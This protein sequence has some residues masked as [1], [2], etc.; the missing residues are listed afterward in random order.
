MWPVYT[1]RKTVTTTVE[2]TESRNNKIIELQWNRIQF[3]LYNE[4]STIAKVWQFLL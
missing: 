2:L 3:Y 1:Y 4:Y